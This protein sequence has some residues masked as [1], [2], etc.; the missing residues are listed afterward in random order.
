GVDTREHS[1]MSAQELIEGATSNIV[2]EYNG[3]LPALTIDAV[4]LNLAG[5]RA[6]LERALV[7]LLRNAAEAGASDVHITAR[8]ED[9]YVVT[10]E[11]ENGARRDDKGLYPLSNI[12][13]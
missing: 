12:F 9:G 4:S 11:R 6:A 2:F 7:A 10:D 13:D 1:Q 3:P 8:E 5:D